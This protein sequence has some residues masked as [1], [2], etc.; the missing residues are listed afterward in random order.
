M[1]SLINKKAYL[2]KFVQLDVDTAAEHSSQVGGAGAQVAKT[3]TP[4]KL[5]LFGLHQFLHLFNIS[6]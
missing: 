1:T 5:T 6:F 2:A 3:L 4:R